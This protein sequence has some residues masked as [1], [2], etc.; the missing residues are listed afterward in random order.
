VLLVHVLLHRKD[1]HGLIDALH[2]LVN[3]I[4]DLALQQISEYVKPKHGNLLV[5]QRLK[6][7]TPQKV[8][9][10]FAEDIAKKLVDS[11]I[12]RNLLVDASTPSAENTKVLYSP[13]IAEV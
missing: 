1:P 12:T 3:G 4:E 7:E 10:A 5:V 2:Q 6:V 11:E 13:A 8:V 9:V